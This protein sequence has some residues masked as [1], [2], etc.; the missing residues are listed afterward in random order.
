MTNCPT[1]V[2]LRLPLALCPCRA[3][4]LQG[5]REIVSP[6]APVMQP[7]LLS[8]PCFVHAFV[9]MDMSCKVR[10]VV[11]STMAAAS[12]VGDL[13]RMRLCPSS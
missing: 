7:L 6:A 10:R 11:V 13:A 4:L 12:C 1:A 8:T 2:L 3:A 5:V 9:D